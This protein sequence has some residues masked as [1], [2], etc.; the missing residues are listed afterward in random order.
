MFYTENGTARTNRAIQALH[1]IRQKENLVE[2]FTT[3]YLR[4]G[5][6]KKDRKPRGR[7]L[8]VRRLFKNLL[9]RECY[10]PKIEGLSDRIFQQET[11][12][13]PLIRHEV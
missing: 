8:L 13:L 9:A 6:K 10:S 1:N 4:F 7:K 2:S 12:I 5:K 3:F 11:R